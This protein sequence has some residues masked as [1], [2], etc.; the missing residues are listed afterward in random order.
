M[1]N[2]RVLLR[3]GLHHPQ[4]FAVLHGGGLLYFRYFNH[5]LTY[6]LA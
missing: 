5:L 3:A 1:Q 2:A 6:I 4:R